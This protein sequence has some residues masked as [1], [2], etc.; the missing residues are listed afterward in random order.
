[1]KVKT[2]I[3]K[4]MTKERLTLNKLKQRDKQ[5]LWKRKPTESIDPSTA[6]FKKEITDMIQHKCLPL[7]KPKMRTRIIRMMPKIVLDSIIHTLPIWIIVVMLNRRR[8]LV[9]ERIHSKMKEH[10]LHSKR[11]VNQEID[12]EMKHQM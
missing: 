2:Q 11:I 8:E 10:S 12:K 6:M 9:K 1:M 4:K 5:R 7:M 3:L